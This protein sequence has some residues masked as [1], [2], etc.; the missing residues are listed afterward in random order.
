MDMCRYYYPLEPLNSL[1]IA[2][3]NIHLNIPPHL[4]GGGTAKKKMAHLINVIFR[5]AIQ[6]TCVNL[7]SANHLECEGNKT[8]TRGNLLTS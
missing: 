5:M 2:K 4:K 7:S 1:I 6:H 3:T 8:I